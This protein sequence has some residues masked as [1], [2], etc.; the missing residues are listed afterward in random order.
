MNN[1]ILIGY[2]GCG[3]TT[4][5]KHLARMSNSTFV[6]TDEEIEKEQQTTISDI[7]AAQ[8]ENAFRIMETKYLQDLLQSKAESIVLSTGGGMAIREENQKLLKK[9]GTTFYLKAKAETIYER[10]KGDTRRPLLQCENPLQK[11]NEMLNQREPAYEQAAQYVIE[12]DGMKQSEVAKKIYD[13]MNGGANH[14][15]IG[16]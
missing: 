14:E 2:M 16:N 1:V 5:G 4:V 15:V 10:V 7:F 6:D 13:I 8:G 3:K 12:V 11:I 9:V